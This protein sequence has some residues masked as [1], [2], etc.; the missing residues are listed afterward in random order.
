MR[1]PEFSHLNISDVDGVPVITLTRPEKLNALND[2]LF[3]EVGQAI[4]WLDK[5]SES[6]AL[7]LTAEGKGFIAGADLGGYASSGHKEFEAFQSLG[8]SIYD[9][10]RDS[11][12]VVLA[13]VNGYALGGGM[14]MVLASDVVFASEMARLGLPEIGVALLPGGGGTAFLRAQYPISFV[15]DL[16]L[17]G[18]F[19][20][21]QEA[22]E[23]GIVQYVT[24]P[25]NLLSEAVEYAKTLNSRS[26]DAVKRIKKLL[27]PRI[28]QAIGFLQEEREALLELFAGNNAREGINAFLEKREPLFERD[29]NSE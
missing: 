23:R 10:L 28:P 16:I 15:K 5:N 17:S 12:Q 22:L 25:E 13:A 7:I 20:K 26:P 1:Y 14:E 4:S 3:A 8:Q 9:T 24:S 27:D 6:L 11:E 18:R 2:E 21:A 19:M 29:E